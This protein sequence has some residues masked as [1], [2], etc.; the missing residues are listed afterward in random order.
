MPD[1]ITT[2]AHVWTADANGLYQ[3][4]NL[5]AEWHNAYVDL[6]T[7]G[8]ADLTAEQR[9]EANAEAVFENT[10]LS[11]LS[12][13]VQQRDREDAQRQFDAEFAAM[14]LAGIDPNAPI[15]Q[16]S[17]LLLEHTLQSSPMLEELAIQGHG[18]NDPTSVRYRGYTNDFQNNVDANTLFVGGGLNNGKNALT[19]FFDDNIMTHAPFATVVRN[20]KPIQL[21]QNGALETG[22]SAAVTAM[23]NSIHVKAYDADDFKH[24][25]VTA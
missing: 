10:S 22:L 14:A 9:L 16:A 19:D 17:Y 8:G 2:T 13:A 4:G 21:N 5:A 23:N 11:T 1:Q 20:G 15:T 12:A 7:K 6:V 24:P 25:A 18:L 3:T